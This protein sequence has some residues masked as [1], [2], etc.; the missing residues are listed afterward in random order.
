MADFGQLNNVSFEEWHELL[1]DMQSYVMA[2][3]LMKHGVMIMKQE[4]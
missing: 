3:L 4:K 2:V 1:M